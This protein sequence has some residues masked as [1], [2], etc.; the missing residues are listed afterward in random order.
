MASVRHPAFCLSSPTGTERM[1]RTPGALRNEDAS[2][3]GKSCQVLGEDKWEF[4]EKWEDNSMVRTGRAT[5]SPPAPPETPEHSRG[6]RGGRGGT[7]GGPDWGGGTRPRC[8]PR[9][10]GKEEPAVSQR[11]IL[12][13]IRALRLLWHTTN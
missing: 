9:R 4:S 2:F 8:S 1:C 13:L 6:S 7:A 11:T 3:H 10:R 5:R 12:L